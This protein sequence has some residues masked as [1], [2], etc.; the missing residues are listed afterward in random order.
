MEAKFK[1]VKK[2]KKLAP[3]EIKVFRRTDG[4]TVFDHEKHEKKL[5]NVE[6]EPVDEKL[7]RSKPNSLRHLTRM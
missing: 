3:I 6:I 2:E 4:Y 5:K 7:R 1:C